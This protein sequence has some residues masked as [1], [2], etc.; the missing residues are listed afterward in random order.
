[1]QKHRRLYAVTAAVIIMASVV[2]TFDLMA[3][4][5]EDGAVVALAGNNV[6]KMSQQVRKQLDQQIRQGELF[7]EPHSANVM[8]WLCMAALS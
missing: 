8:C 1:M 7:S 4:S 6:P 5:A 3:I 2:F